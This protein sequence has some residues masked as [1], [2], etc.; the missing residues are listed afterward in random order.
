[1]RVRVFNLYFD[2]RIEKQCGA[3]AGE[4]GQRNWICAGDNK[5]GVCVL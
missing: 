3:A 2:L 5:K 1:M 4:V